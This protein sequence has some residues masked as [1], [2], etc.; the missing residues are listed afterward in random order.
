MLT[1]KNENTRAVDFSDSHANYLL[2]LA[3]DVGEELLKSGAEIQRVEN[4]IERI[5]R[6][7]GAVHVEVFAITSWIM[8]SVRLADN[9]YSSQMRRVYSSSYRMSYLESMN[10]I[11]RRICEE[12]PPLEEADAMIRH[13]KATQ[14]NSFWLFLLG[15][16]MTTAAFTLFFGGNVRDAL[17]AM[18]LGFF[19]AIVDRIHPAY[20]NQLA[21]LLI[22]SFVIGCLANFSVL[23]GFGVHVD[24]IIIGAIMVL[25]PGLAFG[26]AIRDLLCGDI[27]AGILKTVQSCLSAVLIAFG[28][29][30]S[31]LLMKEL[32]LTCE[33]LPVEATLPVKAVTAVFGTVGFA[34]F[35]RSKLKYLPM[36]AVCG[37][38]T[39]LIFAFTLSFGVSPFL[40]AFFASI[41]TGI[42][43]E[44]SARICHAPALIFSVL[45]AVSII[46][47]SALYYTMNYM[48][49]G[50]QAQ[51]QSRLKETLLI[52]TGIALGMISVSVLTTA[53][54]RFLSRRKAKKE[55]SLKK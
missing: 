42:F 26:N 37:F 17:V 52:S 50:D 51:M 44:V 8:A 22:V 30:L 23:I 25:I 16:G 41:F 55:S 39:Y 36:I 29:M 38:F 6:A 19:V 40:A 3:L 2:C 27:L 32:G 43:S 28:F 53:I 11:S 7:Y 9:S 49:F 21:K 35:I 45:G 24:A 13:A 14:N 48:L 20:I 18:L 1:E 47:G 10:A 34:F 54:S 4:T 15:S 33:S 5:C 31:A 46:P 12:K